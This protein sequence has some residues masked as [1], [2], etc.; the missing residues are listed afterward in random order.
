MQTT[1]EATEEITGT[2]RRGNE[3]KRTEE[4][5]K[6]SERTTKA[7]AQVQQRINS[8]TTTANIIRANLPW[9]DPIERKGPDLTRFYFQNV[10]GIKS[11]D[12][13]INA[14]EIGFYTN[15]NQVDLLGLAETNLD[16]QSYRIHNQCR[17][18]LASFW[19]QHVFQVASSTITFGLTYQPG[20]V[21]MLTGNRWAS[22]VSKK[23]TDALGRWVYNRMQGRAN[24]NL[25]INA[26]Y[27]PCK[28][29]GPTTAYQQ[30][31][32]LLR[33]RGIGN[34]N[35]QQAFVDN[36]DTILLSLLAKK[37]EFV[38][39]LDANKSMS[40]RK[41]AIARLAQKQCCDCGVDPFSAGEVKRDKRFDVAWS[42]Q[43]VM[44][45]LELSHPCFCRWVRQ[46]VKVRLQCSW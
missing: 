25:T 6:Q 9:G 26:A 45:N 19:Q 35:Q 44:L 21:A 41:S 2:T 27:Q 43:E 32:I 36:L 14:S 13:C 33:P 28:T 46:T 12:K 3:T 40:E 34:P 37:H 31:W 17:H 23:H 1:T 11:W 24:T 8:A 18:H 42:K 20:G 5:T 29:E 38:L 22:R 10:N 4:E 39:I 7:K 16:W 15:V 30:Q